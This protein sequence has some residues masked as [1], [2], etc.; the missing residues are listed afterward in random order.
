MRR[1]VFPVSIV[2]LSMVVLFV[3]GSL[4]SHSSAQDAAPT[5]AVHPIVSSWILDADMTNPSNPPEVAVFG[6]D[7]SYLQIDAEGFTSGVGRWAATG[8]STTDFTFLSLVV[9]GGV[10][11][12]THIVRGAATVDASGNRFTAQFTTEFVVPNGP[13]TGQ[14]GPGRA[15]ALRI[16]VEPMGTSV[17]PIPTPVASPTP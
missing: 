4:S 9:R 8:S 12:G 14:L 15:Q 17:G 16:V 11:V 7:G 10:L 13:A 3:V 6:A 5:P 1:R 2:C